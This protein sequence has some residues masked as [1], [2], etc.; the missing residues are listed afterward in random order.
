MGQ[1]ID[2]LENKNFLDKKGKGGDHHWNYGR[3]SQLD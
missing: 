3:N 1:M 2:I